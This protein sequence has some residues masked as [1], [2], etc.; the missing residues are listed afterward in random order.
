MLGIRPENIA[1]RPRDGDGFAGI[2]AEIVQVEALG[3]ETIL[4][5]RVAGM[6]RDLMA[7]IGPDSDAT[8][9]AR[10]S[11]SLDLSAVHLFDGAGD[12]IV[13]DDQIAVRESVLQRV[14]EKFVIAMIFSLLRKGGLPLRQGG[15]FRAGCSSDRPARTRR[16]AGTVIPLKH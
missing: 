7:R 13:L 11:L 15:N 6:D 9:G 2:E 8:V 4:A 10:R 14:F 12:A 1:A 5:A 16:R 3:A